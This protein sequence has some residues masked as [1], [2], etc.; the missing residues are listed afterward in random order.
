MLFK[1]KRILESLVSNYQELKEKYYILKH[2]YKKLNKSFANYENALNY[3]I[4][5]EFERRFFTYKL[6]EGQNIVIIFDN[7]Y[8]FIGPDETL[9]INCKI[10]V[11]GT[12][13][14]PLILSKNDKKCKGISITDINCG[15]Y[16][17]RGIGTFIINGLVETLKEMD[18]NQI[19]ARLSPYDYSSK[20]KL[21]NFYINKNGFI[22]KEEL[23]ENSWGTVIKYI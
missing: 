9:K 20:D 3:K 23:T 14:A 15:K 6:P 8:N 11:D 1:R 19:S 4:E 13:N 5:H 10:F 2:E 18:I 16:K 17:N 7:N 12:I 21:Y 22:L